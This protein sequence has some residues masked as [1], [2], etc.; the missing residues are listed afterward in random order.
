MI[1]HGVCLKEIQLWLGH[2]VYSTTVNIF[3]HLDMES[4]QETR[5]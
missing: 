2:S 4:K 5:A 1:K 3:T